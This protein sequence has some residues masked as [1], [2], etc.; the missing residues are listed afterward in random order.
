MSTKIQL[1]EEL[2]IIN[3]STSYDLYVDTVKNEDKNLIYNYNNNENN[4][5]IYS[6]LENITTNEKNILRILISEKLNIY[7]NDTH[8]N[9]ILNNILKNNLNTEQIAEK[10]NC[11]YINKNDKLV[12]IGLKIYKRDRLN[13]AFEILVNLEEIDIISIFDDEF[14]LIVVN[15][16]IE[17]AVEL[18]RLIVELIEIEMLEN[19]NIGISSSDIAINIKNLYRESID[20]IKITEKFS[21]PSNVNLYKDIFIYKVISLINYDDIK[22]LYEDIEEYK[23]NELNKDDIKTA[24]VFL[25]LSLNISESARKLY[26]HRNTLIY[27]LEKIKKHTG[28]DLRNFEHALKF[29]FILILKSFINY[30]KRK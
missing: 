26:V 25:N 8:S 22:K 14:I 28:L 13:D 30:N 19:I 21:I 17:K 16:S 23:I 20:T 2:N 4:Y 11:L 27:R 24:E 18:S 7:S 29:K 5:Y 15:N 3:L 10:L 9:K 12:I 1:Q 6:N